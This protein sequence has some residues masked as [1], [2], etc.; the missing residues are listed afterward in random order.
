[1][2][3]LELPITVFLLQAIEQMIACFCGCSQLTVKEVKAI[4]MCRIHE[5][6]ADTKATG[7][8]KRFIINELKDE[9]DNLT[10]KYMVTH[11][12][13]SQFLNTP[14]S[15]KNDALME[16]LE[17]NLETFPNE[18][19]ERR[20]IDALEERDLYKVERALKHLIRSL[21]IEVESSREMQLLK[22]RLL[23]KIDRL[24]SSHK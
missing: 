5:F 7:L 24:G 21:E 17:S 12:Q 2:Y 16:D 13:C 15:H 10:L 8:L 18:R 11:E 23:K 20:L 1:M 19:D 6:L 3:K 9:E 14:K 22:E 4:T